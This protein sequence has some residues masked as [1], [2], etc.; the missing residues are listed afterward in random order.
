[1]GQVLPLVFTALTTKKKIL[2]TNENMAFVNDGMNS[3]HPLDPLS[4]EEM[5]EAVQILRDGRQ[6]S[7]RVRF[8]S[9]ALREPTKAEVCAYASGQ[10][11]AREAHFI[12]L[13]N[14]D[15]Q[16]YEAVVSLTERCV[17]SWSHMPGVQPPI[18]VDEFVECENTV[19]AHPEWQTALR[20]RGITNFEN[21]IVDPWS[22]GNFGDEQFPG[23]RLARGYTWM[24]TSHDDVGY[25][26]P[27][28]GVVAI[29][30]LNTMTV[31]KVED[32]GVVPLPPPSGNYTAAAVGSIR[33]DL[34]PLDIV[35]LD[36][37]S[38]SVDGYAVSWQKWKFRI[39]FT[40]REGLVLYCVGYADRG[41]ER[42][43]LYRV[44][45]SEMVV[46]YGD[47][48]PIHS[49]K[50]AFDVGE[51]GIGRLVNSLELGC[52]CLGNIKYFDAI[53]TDSRGG[54]VVIPK[55]VCMHE[56]D[57]GTLWKHTDW[58][59]NHTEVRRSRR[60]VVSSFA[61]VG[62][63]DYGFFWYFYQSGD[64]QLEVKLT[65]CLSVGALPPD[66]QPKYGVMVSP[67]LY[68]PI[69]QH[70]FNF[71]LHF[72][73]EGEGNSVYEVDTVP[74]TQGPHNPLG[75][76]CHPQTTLLRSEAEA[77][78][79]INPLAG[80][81]WKVINPNVRNNVGQPVGYKIVHGENV[82]PFASPDS[83]VMK[84]AGFMRSHLWVTAY[85]PSEMYASGDYINQ[86]PGG[87]GLPAYVAKDRPLENSD[88][89]VWY[90]CGHHHIPRPEDWPVMPVAYIGFILRPVGFFD[91]NPAMDTPPPEL[92]ASCEVQ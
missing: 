61:T 27:V 87:D 70:F 17:K 79:V 69:H 80:R 14:G 37:P 50:N 6:L 51:Y 33:D 62:N 9:A 88:V 29:V 81:Y 68:A 52:D 47:P 30:D 39:G 60:L 67:Q 7:G 2:M 12:L 43:I 38:F 89:V 73:I 92:R 59:T 49:K 78:R 75:N 13:D 32:H 4:V 76:G 53:M 48:G 57:Y 71:R 90:T 86:H 3:V 22:A 23:H 11:Q 10:P 1:M 28:D 72:M 58:R 16:V 20:R 65:G 5:R 66:V 42:P 15:G 63:Y 56:E 91:A 83:S 54:V 64:I 34:K 82:L 41:R 36:G 26:R 21:A 35:Q 44:S 24:R 8:M 77:Q 85:D 18:H 31:L 74:E 55:A 46:P 45:L 40:P 25:G 19:K 84:R